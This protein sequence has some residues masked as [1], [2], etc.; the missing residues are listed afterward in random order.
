MAGIGDDPND[1]YVDDNDNDDDNDEEWNEMAFWRCWFYI[2]Y[3][4]FL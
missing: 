3:F 1:D 4:N 2:Y